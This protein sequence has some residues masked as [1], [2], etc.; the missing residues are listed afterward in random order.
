APKF[1]LESV[2]NGTELLRSDEFFEVCDSPIVF[3]DY[4]CGEWYDARKERKECDG[5]FTGENLRKAISVPPPKGE[6][7][8]CKAQPIKAFE[9]ISPVRI[10][11]VNGG[12]IYDFGVNF[13]GIAELNIDGENGEE[14]DLTFGEVLQNGELDLSNL[15][16]GERSRK[17][18][19]QHDKYICKAGR[20]TWKPCF[21]YHGFR[22]VYV[23]GISEEQATPDL[24]TFIVLHSDIPQRRK[25]S[26]GD[27]TFGRIQ[28]C[29]LRSD[30]SNFY[31]FPTDCPQREKNGW[32][33]DAALSAEQLLYNFDCEVSLREWL[34]NIRKAQRADGALPGIVPTAGWGFEWGNGPAWDGVLIE[35]TYQLYRFSGDI[36]I[37]SENSE[38]IAKYIDYLYSRINRNGLIGFG[39]G[40]WLEAGAPSPDRYST[41][42]EV[43]DTL[44]CI[45]L[46]R[47][48]EEIYRILGDECKKVK[49]QKLEIDLTENFRKKRIKDHTVDCETQTAQ[50]MA[51]CL[52][53]FEDDDKAYRNLLRIIERDGRFKAGII[54]VRRLFDCLCDHGDGETAYRLITDVRNPGYAHNLELGA[55]TLWEDFQLYDEAAGYGNLKR[56]DGGGILSLNHHCWGSISGWFYRRVAGLVIKSSE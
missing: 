40:D 14:I 41:P 30:L 31:Y 28:D 20:Q 3:D 48:A 37:L 19:V 10:N 35:L 1:Y 43:T 22:Y 8:L 49:A 33:G 6:E 42:V 21:T 15:L 27:R 2:Q 25:F 47:K 16:F 36:D 17:G 29:T 23:Q 46:L 52:G 13:A 24:L 9:R 18:F 53:L 32:T 39:L 11:R 56:L 50:A 12:Y 55:T 44:T 54:G 38:A 26:C 4:R 5:L 51:I 7:K 45:E 34:S